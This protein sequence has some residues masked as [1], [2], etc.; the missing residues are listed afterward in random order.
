MR[1]DDYLDLC[2]HVRERYGAAGLCMLCG[3]ASCD[4]TPDYAC[5]GM[6][7]TLKESLLDARGRIS[8]ISLSV[9]KVHKDIVN[10]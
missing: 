8:G 6:C 7:M 3:S 2:K 5:S 10:G 9:E 4:L 1:H